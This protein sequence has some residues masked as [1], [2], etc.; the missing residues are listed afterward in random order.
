LEIGKRITFSGYKGSKRV[1]PST[2]V[3]IFS[4]NVESIGIRKVNIT[5]YKGTFGGGEGKKGG[6]M[7]Q[8]TSLFSRR[9]SE[10]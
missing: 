3:L 5:A 9:K 1:L 6:Q 10:I 2:T 4:H 8:A 7:A